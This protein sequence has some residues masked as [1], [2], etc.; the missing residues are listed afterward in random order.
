[1]IQMTPVRCSSKS[2]FCHE[3]RV[4]RISSVFKNIG[5][6][7]VLT[8]GFVIG[9]TTTKQVLI[10]AVGPTFG[11]PPFSFFGVMADPKLDLFSGQTVINSN[12]NWG[13]GTAFTTAFTRVGAFGLASAT[14]KDAV[15]LVTLA[16]GSYTAQVSGVA[17]SSGLTLV[18]IY[19]VP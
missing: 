4:S 12:D 17:G 14:S 1:M 6:G 16:P 19:E 3:E 15:L 8:A 18:E 11:A 13:G 7:E 5:A 10:R 9:G 2:T